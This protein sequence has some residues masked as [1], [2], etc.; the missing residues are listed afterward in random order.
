MFQLVVIDDHEIMSVVSSGTIAS[1]VSCNMF[2]FVPG[3]IPTISNSKKARVST[4][5]ME[6]LDLL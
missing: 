5:L 3:R 4:G 1:M 6:C 2:K